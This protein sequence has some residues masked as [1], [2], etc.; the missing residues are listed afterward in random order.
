M[1]N[2][3]RRHR[4][5]I[6][7]FG[8]L[9]AVVVASIVIAYAMDDD[10]LAK[11]IQERQLEVHFGWGVAAYLL[12]SRLLLVVE[13]KAKKRGAGNLSWQ[14]WY[15]GPIVALLA[16]VTF[17]EFWPYG[18]PKIGDFFREEVRDAVT[19]LMRPIRWGERLKSVVDYAGWLF[20]ALGAA[21]YTYFTA[22]RLET[23]RQQ[24]LSWK[25]SR[26]RAA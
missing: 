8:G 4:L 17:Q 25:L 15:F 13:R 6:G 9:A 24:Y 5:P 2:W 23:A 14:A 16:C 12:F 19:G 18:F 10:D 21:W 20:G 11:H 7:V 22:T 26:Q 3:I 1:K